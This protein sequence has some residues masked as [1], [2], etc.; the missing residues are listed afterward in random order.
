MFP[1]M[2]QGGGG[3]GFACF[4]S[5]WLN[6][7]HR[8][9]DS[10]EFLLPDFPE[11]SKIHATQLSEFLK[12]TIWSQNTIAPSQMM[13]LA[14]A[15]EA[16]GKYFIWVVRPQL[17]FDINSEFKANEWLPEGFE[18]RINISKQRLLV[19]SWAPQLDI[20]SHK[21]VSAFLSHCEW[22]SVLESLCHGVPIMGWPTA[23]EQFYNVKL[24]EEEILCGETSRDNGQN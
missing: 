6:L 18:E 24:L 11:A 19:H 17:G 3:F 21:S 15:L 2:A 23:A 5:L 16:S 14:L 1:F 13:E 4:Y 20:L 7:P 12:V 22:N 9:T 10:D 8:N